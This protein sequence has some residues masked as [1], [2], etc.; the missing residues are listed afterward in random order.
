MWTK[1]HP[2]VSS[3]R[4]CASQS[5]TSNLK[6]ICTQRMTFKK[7]NRSYWLLCYILKF[8]WLFQN[9]ERVEVKNVMTTCIVWGG[10][11]TPVYGFSGVNSFNSTE[12]LW[13]DGWYERLRF[14]PDPSG[15]SEEDG[16]EGKRNKT[17]CPQQLL[18]ACQNSDRVG[19]SR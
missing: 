1:H 14:I 12:Q 16:L 9:W 3:W 19:Y 11:L 18:W 7:I 15:G 13:A 4:V 6:T 2:S 5:I 17:C 8:K 10:C